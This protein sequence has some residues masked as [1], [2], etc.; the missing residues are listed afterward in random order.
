MTAETLSA[1]VA[2]LLALLFAY[3]PGFATWFNPLESEKKR[4]IMLGFLVVAAVVIF[5]LSCAQIS[6][7]VPCTKEGVW[8][9]VQILGAAIIA[10]QSLFAILPKV[11]LNKSE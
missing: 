9:L 3:I 2:A 10:N 6:P 8:S 5:G 1:I 7:Y 11:G 4:L